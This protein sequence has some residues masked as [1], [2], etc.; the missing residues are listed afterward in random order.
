MKPDGSNL[1][2]VIQDSLVCLYPPPDISWLLAGDARSVADHDCAVVPS[3]SSPGSN[4]VG[5][6]VW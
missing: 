3:S 2:L 4:F 1:T 6:N 5:Q